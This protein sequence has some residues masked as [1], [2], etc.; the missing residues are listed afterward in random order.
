MGCFVARE[1]AARLGR[2]LVVDRDATA[3]ERVAGLPGV[4]VERVDLAERG[5][6]ARFA[7][8]GK[9]SV[10]AVPGALG[11]RVR[12]EAIE[13][14]CAV[15]DI[16]FSPEDPWGDDEVARARRCVVV[17]D[18]GVAP[19]LSNLFAAL[20]AAQLERVASV[21]IHVGGLPLRRVWPFEY[22]APFSP[23]DVIEEYV[24]PC[25]LKRGG[26]IVVR[27]ALSEVE[28]VECEEVGTLEAF[29]TDGLRTL[30]RTLPAEDME[31]KTLRY[32]GHAATMELLREAGFF[33][34]QAIRIGGLEV[35][36]RSLTE[37]LLARAWTAAP[38]EEEFTLLRVFV[39]GRS[40][41]KSLEHRWELFDRTDPTEGFSSMARTTGLPC[42]L[43]AQ[44]LAEGRWNAPGVHP[45]EY[46]ARDQV[47]ADWLIESVRARGVRIEHDVRASAEE[48]GLG[49]GG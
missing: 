36:P 19:G 41:G 8:R 23:A 31:E 49:G 25:R 11:A 13:A 5:Q 47:L 10:V 12:R 2:V 45:P 33:G 21:R 26:K 34:T 15:V 7:A 38:G 44:A 37:A 46:L 22:R 9:V 39:A 14:S 30:L 43:V 1:L 20:S 17:V 28:R 3:L 40:G 6:A 42:A 48:P 27:P 16:A 18:C 24:R 35:A 29:L 4:A 32:P